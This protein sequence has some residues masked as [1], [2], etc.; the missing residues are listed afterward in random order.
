MP[1]ATEGS[2]AWKNANRNLQSM[3]LANTVYPKIIFDQALLPCHTF[4]RKE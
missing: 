1:Y 2:N 3:V 4:I